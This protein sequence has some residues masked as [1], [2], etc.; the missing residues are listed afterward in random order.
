MGIYKWG[1]Y[2]AFLK[3]LWALC[4]VSLFS[5]EVGQNS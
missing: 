5:G 2:I 3:T 4:P 1:L